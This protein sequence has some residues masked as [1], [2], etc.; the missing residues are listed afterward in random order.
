MPSAVCRSDET[1]LGDLGNDMEGRTFGED[2]SGSEIDMSSLLRSPAGHQLVRTD[3]ELVCR[4]TER[5]YPIIDGNAR[6]Y[7]A[8]DV[9]EGLRA[10]AAAFDSLRVPDSLV[11]DLSNENERAYA[12]AKRVNTEFMFA[13][14]RYASISNRVVLELGAWRCELISRFADQGARAFAL[15]FFHGMVDAA[16]RQHRGLPFHRISS[17]MA[18]LPFQDASVDLLFMHATLHHALPRKEIDFEWCNPENMLDAVREIARVLKPD[19]AF[20]LLGEGIYPEG[21]ARE[22]RPYEKAAQA[23]ESCYESWYTLSEYEHVFKVAGRFPTVMSSSAGSELELWC[24][25]EGK[26]CD[27]LKV[28]DLVTI[29][30]L[31]ERFR[32]MSDWNAGKDWPGRILPPWISLA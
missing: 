10:E 18:V 25:E 14:L 22:D 20:F 7:D 2:M 3:S 6:I 32:M 15:D 23:G 30:A 29:E 19:G 1:F 9:P 21:L 26:R 13:C 12:A 24:Y 5:R 28:G 27:L 17:P 31:A 11:P 4:G 8:E 16:A